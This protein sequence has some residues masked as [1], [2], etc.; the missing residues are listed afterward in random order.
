MLNVYFNYPNSMISMHTNLCCPTIKSQLK[1]NQRYIVINITTIS[2]ELLNFQD[3]FYKFDSTAHVNDMWVEVDFGDKAFEEA[4]VD[5]IHR[6][7]SYYT[8]FSN[9]SPQFCGI[10]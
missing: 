8:P 1:D 2:Y 9:A 6:L 10:C 5:Y 3:R 7:L 4:V